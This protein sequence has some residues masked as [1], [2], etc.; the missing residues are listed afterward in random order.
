[1][2]ST[3]SLQ[4]STIKKLSVKFISLESNVNIA[5]SRNSVMF[6]HKTSEKQYKGERVC[7][8]E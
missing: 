7:E 2:L 3:T 1:M 5:R 8:K 6:F 4:K